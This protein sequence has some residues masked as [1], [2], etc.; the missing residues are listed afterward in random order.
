MAEAIARDLGGGRIVVHSAGLAPT[1]W[2]APHTVTALA[3]LG[4]ASDDLESKGLDDVPLASIDVVI[5]LLGAD[6]LRLVPPS[7]GERREMWSIRDP[8]G[9]DLDV[10]RAVARELETRIRL[11]LDELLN[12]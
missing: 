11:L 1:G 8:Y 6:G 2:I 3:E 5:S 4:Y 10:Y 9:D 7:V 12:E